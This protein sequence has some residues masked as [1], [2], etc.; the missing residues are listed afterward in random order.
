MAI[1]ENSYDG[2]PEVLG[3]V[4]EPS[5]VDYQ[6]PDDWLEDSFVGDEFVETMS[7]AISFLYGEEKKTESSELP[8]VIKPQ[9]L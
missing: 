6:E 5:Q 9:F 8:D 3:Q 4:E 2:S 7:I 1:L